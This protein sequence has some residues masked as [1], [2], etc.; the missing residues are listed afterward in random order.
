VQGSGKHKIVT[1]HRPD[2][3]CNVEITKHAD[4]IELVISPASRVMTESL[5]IAKLIVRDNKVE[6]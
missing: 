2:Y 6:T 1:L 3:D 4:R 5:Q